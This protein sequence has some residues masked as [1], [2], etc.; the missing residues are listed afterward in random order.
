MNM[1]VIII[2]ISLKNELNK[3]KVKKERAKNKFFSVKLKRPVDL[4]IF[5]VL[6]T[7]N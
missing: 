5:T 6:K 4:N 2:S 1:T 7:V 3:L